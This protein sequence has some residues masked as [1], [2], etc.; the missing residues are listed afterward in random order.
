MPY[1]D[2]EHN[3]VAQDYIRNH[4]K[5]V[6]V[7]DGQVRPLR[8]REKE[9]FWEKYRKDRENI[10]NPHIRERDR[11]EGIYT[12]GRM[13]GTQ[14][15]QEY[16]ESQGAE[17]F[18]LRGMNKGLDVDFD[19]GE[20][21]EAPVGTVNY[22]LEKYYSINLED[23]RDS[24]TGVP[25]WELFFADRDAAIELVPEA[26]QPMVHQWLNRRETEVRRNMRK[27]FIA[28]IEPSGYLRR[29]ETVALNLGLNLNKMEQV[30]VD[31]LTEEGR[32][33]T[34]SDVGKFIDGQLN[35]ALENQYGEGTKNLSQLRERARELNPGLD[36]ELFRQGFVSTVRSEKAQSILRSLNKKHPDFGYLNAPLANDIKEAL[37]KLR[38]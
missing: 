34:P 9:A 7:T 18:E 35:L 5:V 23:Y 13:D 11:I 1:A 21:G 16:G 20:D 31:A 26:M 24:E 37:K 6:A 4:E 3:L 33:A 32:R 38:G 15:R 14:Y 22:A 12:E 29:R 30:V 28:V 10:K 25:D 36:A 8:L 17:F 27:E 2:L 19:S